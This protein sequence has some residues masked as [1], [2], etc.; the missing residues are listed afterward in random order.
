MNSQHNR[1]QCPKGTFPYRIRPGDNLYRL[2]LRYDTTVPAILSANP[3]IYRFNLQINRWI[4]IPR[5]PFYS[6]EFGD[7]NYTA[8]SAECPKG[9]FA[10]TTQRGDTIH[11]LAQRFNMTVEEIQKVNPDV[12]P[13]SLLAGQ[14]LNIP[15][16]K[17]STYFN[18]AYNVSLQYPAN[19]V[20]TSAGRFQGTDGF[21]EVEAISS[22]AS[23]EDVYRGQSSGDSSLYITN[24][25]TSELQIQGQEAR[26][27][28]PS[29]EQQ[30]GRKKQHAALIVRY[31]K[32]IPIQ[33]EKG[34]YNYLLLRT[35]K[36][37]ISDIANTIRFLDADSTGQ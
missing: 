24:P 28:M 1:Q 15:G 19:W 23:L 14:R 26:L 10:H 9:T 37:H 17:L 2:A 30:T 7:S 12:N 34:D 20:P 32:P 22:N 4:N 36:E 16:G 33:G 25:V 21:F 5:M 35:D 6:T 18:A 3:G 11:S 27:I 31:P 13:A 29:E 8:P